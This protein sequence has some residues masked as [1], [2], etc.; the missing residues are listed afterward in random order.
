VI[1]NSKKFKPNT[2]RAEFIK[3]SYQQILKTKELETKAEKEKSL[4][5]NILKNF[6]NEAIDDPYKD[7]KAKSL[8]K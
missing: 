7:K 5:K 8:S 2:F 6:S 1:S 3:F 4:M